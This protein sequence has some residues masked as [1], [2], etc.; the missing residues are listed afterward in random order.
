MPNSDFFE[1]SKANNKQII[2]QKG[3]ELNTDVACDIV[4]TLGDIPFIGSLVKLT[5]IGFG[6]RDYLFFEKVC[7]FLDSTMDISDNEIDEFINELSPEKKEKIAFFLVNTL[8]LSDE[9]EKAEIIGLIYKYRVRKIINDAIMIRLCAIVN[10][11]FISDLRELG[12][13]LEAKTTSSYMADNLFSLG[14]LANRGI[15]GG[16]VGDPN[17]G[18][19][20]YQLNEIGQC[21]HWILSKEGWL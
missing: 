10:R 6:I 13:Y 20:I 17:S 11:A 19:I 2:A 5:K 1:L 15:N 7:K 8:S 4:E 9:S 18:G 12:S 16:T 21:L 14:L 3:M